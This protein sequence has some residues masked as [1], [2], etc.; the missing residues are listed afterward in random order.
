MVFHHRQEK[1]GGIAVQIIT[2]MESPDTRARVRSAADALL[3]EG[4]RPTVA[5]VRARIGRGSAT[6]IN[7][8]LQDWWVELGERLASP[9]RYALP[10]PVMALAEQLW[11]AARGEANGLLEAQRQQAQAEIEKAQARCEVALLAQAEAEKRAD[12]LAERF[13]ELEGLRLELERA[14]A[15]ERGQRE[16]L[17]AQLQEERRRGAEIQVERQREREEADKR[18]MLEQRRFES[19]EARL[20]AQLDERKVALARLEKALRDQKQVWQAQEMELQSLLREA[21][22][23]ERDQIVRGS[24][25]EAELQAIRTE[26]VQMQE[27]LAAAEVQAQSLRREQALLEQKMRTLEEQTA[28]LTADRNDIEKERNR[29]EA[30]LETLQEEHVSLR[31]LIALQRPKK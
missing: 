22:K 29:L 20:T 9:E 12:R 13:D 6:T 26:K 27:K 10:Q 7:D 3:A 4:I 17:L 18:S 11:Q 14:L 23:R 2:A 8:A 31:H 16:G 15:N 21:S 28:L 1:W 24:R 5:N 30:K 25:L 19:A